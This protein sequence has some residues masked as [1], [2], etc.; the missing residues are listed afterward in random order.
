MSIKRPQFVKDEH[1]EFL[2]HVREAG[3]TNMFGAAPYLIEE[4]LDLNRFQAKEILM[5]WMK[6]F[7]ERHPI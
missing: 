2:D 3:Y 4:F 7:E 6:S 5:Y 1:L